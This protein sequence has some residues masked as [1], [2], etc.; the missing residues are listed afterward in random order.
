MPGGDRTGPQGLGPR[1]GRR[2]GYCMGYGVPGYM[3]PGRGM[4]F[5]MGRGRGMGA[6]F[7]RRYAIPAE[8]PAVIPEPVPMQVPVDTA[9][10]DELAALRQ[11]TEKMAQA[12]DSITERLARLEDKSE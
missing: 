9:A 12:L 5:G 2:A 8:Y 7:G 1:T 3:N 6:G 11:T 4:G 10:V